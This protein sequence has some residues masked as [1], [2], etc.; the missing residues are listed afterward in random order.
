MARADEC[1]SFCGD[2]LIQC[3]EVETHIN[4]AVARRTLNEVRR[5]QERTVPKD[6][7]GRINFIAQ[8]I[9]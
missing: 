7:V 9:V 2:S 8:L 6:Q 1:I 4:V 3:E 5:I